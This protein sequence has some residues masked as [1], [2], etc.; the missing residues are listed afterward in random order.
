MV[1][2]NLGTTF[3]AGTAVAALTLGVLGQLTAY[4][5]GFLATLL[6]AGAVGLAGVLPVHGLA[7]WLSRAGAGVSGWPARSAAAVVWS[8][9]LSAL[10][11]MVLLGLPHGWETATAGKDFV[12]RAAWIAAVLVPAVLG[13]HL[14]VGARDRYRRARGP[15]G[16]HR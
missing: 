15:A 11:S 4:A 16:R 12:L 3:W 8:L 13:A 1:D 9:L 6:L 14:A 5:G 2:G 7:R 10:A